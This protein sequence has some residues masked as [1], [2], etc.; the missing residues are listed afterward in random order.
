MCIRSRV[1]INNTEAKKVNIIEFIVVLVFVEG[2]KG[3]QAD[4][5][6]TCAV[7]S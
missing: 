1:V 4:E 3:K 2:E 7:A 6:K 5:D